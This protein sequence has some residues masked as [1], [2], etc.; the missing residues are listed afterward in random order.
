MQDTFCMT[1]LWRLFHDTPVMLV[2]WHPCKFAN[3]HSLL[4]RKHFS[5]CPP[6]VTTYMVNDHAMSRSN[7]DKGNS[8]WTEDLTQ[9]GYTQAYQERYRLENGYCYRLKGD[10]N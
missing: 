10:S 7:T 3:E 8:K 5:Y 4:G 2:P 1:P 9:A 6:T